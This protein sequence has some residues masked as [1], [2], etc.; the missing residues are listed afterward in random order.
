[1]EASRT[2]VACSTVAG[3]SRREFVRG[4]AAL[5]AVSAVPTLIPGE[6]AASVPG[7]AIL[8]NDAALRRKYPHDAEQLFE[9]VKRFAQRQR[10]EIVRL[11]GDQP[12]R[13]IKARLHRLS[14]R[15]SRLVIFGDESCVP[16]FAVKAPGV[17][18]EIDWF[19]GD[20]DG[21]GLSEIAIA[22]VIGSPRAMT[23]QLGELPDDAYRGRVVTYSGPSFVGEVREAGAGEWVEN[24]E[25]GSNRFRIVSETSSE[26]ILQNVSNAI[27][28]KLDLAA[29]KTFW[30]R[31][32]QEPWVANYDIV[33]IIGSDRTPSSEGLYQRIVYRRHEGVMTDF[34]SLRRVGNDRWIGINRDGTSRHRQVAETRAEL[35]LHNLQNNIDVKFDL[36]AR[37]TFWRPNANEAWR[38][39]PSIEIVE[40][41]ENP[42]SDG[43]AA[44]NALHA[45]VFS[46]FPHVHVETNVMA[47]LLRDLGCAFEQR[48]WPDLQ[49]MARA[50]A[51]WFC[52]HGNPNGWYGGI[53]GTIVTAAN[54]PMLHGQPIVYAGA[55]STVVP[56]APIL[57]AF[58]ERGC[59]VY[60][61]AASDGYGFTPAANGNELGIHYIDAIRSNPGGSVAD[62]AAAARNRYIR[63]NQLAPVMLALERG[64]APRLN[65]V[66]AHTA[67]QWMV[68]GDITATHPRAKPTSAFSSLPFGPKPIVVNSGATISRRFDITAADGVPTLF[69]RGDWDREVSASLQIEVIQNGELMH[70]LDWREQREYWAFT[71]GQAGGH[72]EAGRYQA[73][74][75]LPL[76]SYPGANEVI[77]HV[78]QASK[79]VL[80]G[81]Q[82][83]VQK[84]P[85]RRPP[86]LP[87]P[88][89]AR[90]GGKT[91]LWLCREDLGPMRGALKSIPQQLNYLEQH[92][93]GER[94]AVFEFPDEAEHLIDLSNFDAI[95][96]DDVG[97]GY[98]SFPRGMGARVREF[99]RA[100][101]GL[102][103]AGG[104]DSFNGFFYLISQGGYGGT[105]VEDVL[106]VRMV[107]AHDC[108][109]GKTSVSMIDANHPIAA[110]LSGSLPPIFGYN[111]V[112]AKPAGRVLARTASGDPLLA[113]GQYGKGRVVAFMTRTNR[114]WGADF[115]KWDQYNK[116]WANVI[117]WVLPA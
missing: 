110:G 13:A 96:I 104:R 19:Y 66:Q 42:A 47:T 90:E 1:M 34:G 62:H 75:V 28:F 77:L 11:D 83:S 103:M 95:L 4:A 87:A 60:M 109:E 86:W 43:A 67:L 65:P 23:R 113:V 48:D 50:D 116:F 36:A 61:G 26:I 35:V 8:V 27:Q 5:G 49:S 2:D 101:G 93:F 55:C 16:R 18:L 74:A 31:G 91:L 63:D 54:V 81:T 97:G 114:D 12:A 20:L 68:F 76:I 78:A 25:Q 22:R 111:Q 85:K 17:E 117:R 98:R 99:V 15:P 64:E 32:T 29:R 89:F 7:T 56:G 106:P 79:A 24:N 52:G 82:S 44:S 39:N 46:T 80:I 108:V 59:R 115:K 10:A 21:D 58:M 73:F 53:T 70:R 94:L 84:W 69:F 40:I 105:P 102:V 88:R 92:D 57:R 100:G 6:A 14:P 72:W 38:P 41:E 33:E 9:G 71:E 51:I 107:K 30:R 112:E 3:P 37:K 45:V